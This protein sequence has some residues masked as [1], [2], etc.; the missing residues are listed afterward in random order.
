MA[1]ELRLEITLLSDATFGR[2][3]GVAGLIDAEVEHDEYGLPFL[4]GRTI[5]GL[6][7]EECANLLYALSAIPSVEA[8]AALDALSET[9]SSLFGEAGSTTSDMGLLKVG[10]ATLPESFRQAIASELSSEKPNKLSKE[11]VLAAMTAIR[12]QTAVSIET[13]A[14]LKNSLRS[15]RVVLRETAF[16]A[17]LTLEGGIDAKPARALLSACAMGLRRGGTGRNR[18]R[19]RLICRLLNVQGRE[20]A[21]DCFANF[22]QILQPAT[23]PASAAGP[24]NKEEAV[25]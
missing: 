22:R 17:L 23:S 11:E 1:E 13:G 7:V 12:R 10:A 16:V 19:G 18:G 2:G 3:D 8:Q 9:A 4:R 24:A 14:P 15:M 20:I 25:A 21:P 6:L 5:K